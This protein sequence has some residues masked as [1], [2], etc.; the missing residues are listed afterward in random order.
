M[1]VV[2]VGAFVQPGFCLFILIDAF[3]Q[4][5]AYLSGRN[6]PADFRDIRKG[7]EISFKVFIVIL[8]IY[9]LIRIC[10]FLFSQWAWENFHKGL[11]NSV[12]SRRRSSEVEPLL[13]SRAS[14]SASP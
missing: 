4:P 6:L 5:S 7:Q 13:S 12:F 14:V 2:S 11:L 3:V 9:L 10:V 8:S 1:W